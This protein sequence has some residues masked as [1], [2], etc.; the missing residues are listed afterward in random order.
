MRLFQ[1][2][3]SSNDANVFQNVDKETYKD[4]RRGIIAA[5]LHTDMVKH[6]EMIKEL[7]LLYQMNSDALD[8]LKADT[9]V[10]SSASTTQ[11]IMNALLHCADIGNPMKPWDICYQ[12]AHLCLDEFFA[13]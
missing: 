1:V 6:N 9:V 4:M 13:Q 5:I 8:A 11:T 12:L 2:V 3:N 10:L 7:S